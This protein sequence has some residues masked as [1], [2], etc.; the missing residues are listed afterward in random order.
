MVSP[1]AGRMV[2]GF[3]CAKP[4]T[5]LMVTMDCKYEPGTCPAPATFPFDRY[6]W[7]VT[8]PFTL[9][10]TSEV[11]CTTTVVPAVVTVATAVGGAAPCDQPS[12]GP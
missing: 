11:P 4:P 1:V 3:A 9:T 5:S 2:I 8:D 7:M 6:S 10:W 12:E